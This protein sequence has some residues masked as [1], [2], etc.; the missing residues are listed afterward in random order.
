MADSEEE[1]IL[2]ELVVHDKYWA[3]KMM[4]RGK[5]VTRMHGLLRFYIE[6]GEMVQSIA[7][8]LGEVTTYNTKAVSEWLA[9]TPG[10]CGFEVLE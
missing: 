3:L 9:Y 2:S 5:T 10:S 8:N 1:D 4:W 6:D 7:V